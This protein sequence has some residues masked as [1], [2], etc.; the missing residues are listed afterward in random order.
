MVARLEVQSPNET[1]DSRAVMVQIE[2]YKMLIL[3]RVA[4]RLGRSSEATAILAKARGY[5][6]GL[7]DFKVLSEAEY[8]SLYSQTREWTN[9]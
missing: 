4:E 7:R 3:F 2:L 9:E 5:L 6:Q 8:F 1:I